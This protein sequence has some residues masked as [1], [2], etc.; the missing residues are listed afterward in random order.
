[1]PKG[2]WAL[3]MFLK[4]RESPDLSDCWT[5]PCGRMAPGQSLS[6]MCLGVGG[7]VGMTEQ[8]VCLG[9]GSGA[10]PFPTSL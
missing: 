8:A 1:M 4:G 5:G 6:L 10:G 2:R 3:F 9:L 7:Q